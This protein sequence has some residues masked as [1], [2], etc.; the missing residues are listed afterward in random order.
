[1]QILKVL[2]VV[3]LWVNLT[4]GLFFTKKKV[5][6]H[7]PPPVYPQYAA[8]HQ[9]TYGYNYQ[10]I[11]YYNY[12]PVNAAP[13]PPVPL[14]HSAPPTYSTP[15]EHPAPPAPLAA[16]VPP[17]IPAIHAVP[18]AP[19]ND[20]SHVTHLSNKQALPVFEPASFTSSS[21]N[22][23]V[24]PAVGFMMGSTT[25]VI[26][27]HKSEGKYIELPVET[28]Q[29]V[30]NIPTSNKKVKNKEKP[31]AKTT[32]IKLNSDEFAQSNSTAVLVPKTSVVNDAPKEI[33]KPKA[34]DEG[35]LAIDVR[36]ADENI[37]L[38]SKTMENNQ[39]NSSAQQI[40]K[41][42]LPVDD[43]F[44]GKENTPELKDAPIANVLLNM[45]VLKQASASAGTSVLVDELDSSSLEALTF[46]EVQQLLNE[47]IRHEEFDEKRLEKDTVSSDGAS[48]TK[49][50]E[51]DPQVSYSRVV[52]Q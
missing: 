42:I 3:V 24:I 32:L 30:A 45:R 9:N 37:E 2:L 36:T 34:V 21:K 15:S 18:A 19:C 40:G 5:H 10:P 51:I 35:V 26:E 11:P 25:D 13:A 46:P 50:V 39:N 4:T 27:V 48:T 22:I 44:S 33:I 12:E 1:M 23:E 17:A 6:V 28:V 47:L 38:L 49:L 29:T 7:H 20:P 41:V 31:P 8:P 52:R 16:P 43:M 14:T